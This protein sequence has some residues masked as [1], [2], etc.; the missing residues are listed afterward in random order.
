[1][2]HRVPTRSS[3][4]WLYVLVEIRTNARYL[5]LNTPYFVRSAMLEAS[6]H[7]SSE[8]LSQCEGEGLAPERAR[9]Q[10]L[11]SENEATSVD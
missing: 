3:K 11:R 7:P 4:R 8:L 10:G 6:P 1:M 5:A 2:L 9:P